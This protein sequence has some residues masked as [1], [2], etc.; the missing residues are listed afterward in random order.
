MRERD[1]RASARPEHA[2]GVGED[3]DGTRQ[4]LDRDRAKERVEARVRVGQTRL[5]VQVVHGE[6]GE[7]R[8]ALQLVR[9]HPEA[10]DTPECHAVGKMRHPR[11]HEVQDVRAG[12]EELVIGARQGGDRRVVDV[13]DEARDR[14]EERVGRLVDAVEEALRELGRIVGHGGR[15]APAHAPAPPRRRS[16]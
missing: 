13:D 10:R 8:V 12:G 4:V 3:L 5:G 14:V 6:V 7:S 11:G 2:R 9:V 15:L 16:V 1:E